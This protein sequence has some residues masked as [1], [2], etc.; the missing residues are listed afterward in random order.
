M[1][2]CG[3]R[4]M[5]PMSVYRSDS[6]SRQDRLIVTNHEVESCYPCHANWH[7]FLA[8]PGMRLTSGEE[9]R[10]QRKM[11]LTPMS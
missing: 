9:R 4:F 6:R 11:N 7:E 8:V 10:C 2:M 3:N 1:P 5:S